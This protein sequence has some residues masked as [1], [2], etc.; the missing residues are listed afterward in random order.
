MTHQGGLRR[1]S[2]RCEG[3]RQLESVHSQA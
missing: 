1:R 3:I 2:L